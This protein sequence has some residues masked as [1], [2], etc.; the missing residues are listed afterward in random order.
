M[1]KLEQWQVQSIDTYVEICRVGKHGI[2]GPWFGPEVDLLA[3]KIRAKA[4]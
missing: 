4:P 1:A 3:E 2:A